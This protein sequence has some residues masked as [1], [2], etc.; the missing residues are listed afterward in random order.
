MG[1]QGVVEVGVVVLK[2]GYTNAA[3]DPVQPKEGL[4]GPHVEHL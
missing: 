3:A 4:L 1:I 2:P